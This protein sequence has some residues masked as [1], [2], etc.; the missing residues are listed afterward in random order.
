[1][2]PSTTSTHQDGDLTT[3]I[4]GIGRELAASLARVLDEL[5]AGHAGPQRLATEMGLDK[6]FTS[7]LLRAARHSHPGGTLH[8]LPG[9]APLRRF[10]R[11]ARRSGVTQPTLVLA[12][13]AVGEFARLLEEVM[14]DRGALAAV[15]AAWIPEARRE[16]FARRKQ[17]AFR[18][19]SELR[20]AACDAVTASVFLSPGSSGRI[21]VLW[22]EGLWGL[23]KLRPGVAVKLTSRRLSG[24]AHER[25][26]TTLEGE[27]LADAARGYLTEF[28]TLEPDALTVRVAGDRVDYL[29]KSDEY[30]PRS[31]ADLVW[32]ETLVDEMPL[33][34][35]TNRQAYA[36]ADVCV[37]SRTLVFDAFLHEELLGTGEPELAIYDTSF[38]G[39]VDPNDPSRACDLVDHAEKLELLGHGLNGIE[40]DALPAYGE[41][42]QYVHRVSG[43]DPARFHGYRAQV[44]YPLYGT[45]ITMSFA[46]P[47][48]R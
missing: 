12:E 7:R 42:L 20:G 30:G 8:H 35:P 16:F 4:L 44:Q 25:R 1:M 23:R 3:T 17:A 48:V 47:G 9:P 19:M 22:L 39:A 24:E 15:L 2:L 11:N 21:D 18:A 26:P 29:I 6:A 14:G 37:P 43:S 10:L 32:A 33:Q 5:P 38:A 41:L 13:N 36:F 27:P 40:L 46:S 28:T 31:S 34:P 45:Q